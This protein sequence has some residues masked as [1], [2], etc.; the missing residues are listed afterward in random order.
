MKKETNIG[1]V[2]INTR[3]VQYRMVKMN[4]KTGKVECPM[5]EGEFTRRGIKKHIRAHK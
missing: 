4:I 2:R 3:P 1:R 5:C